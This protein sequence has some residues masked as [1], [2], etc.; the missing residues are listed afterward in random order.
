MEKTKRAK[1]LEAA[2]AVLMLTLVYIYAGKMP[3]LKASTDKA[4]TKTKEEENVKTVVIDPGHGGID[5]GAVSVR[6]A[7]EKDINLSIGLMLRDKLKE[8]G[9]A[10]VMTRETD[11]GLYGDAASN[12]K[13]ADMKARC[14]LINETEP[15]IMV[16]IHQNNYQ[17]EGVKGAQTFYYTNSSEGERAAAI[18]QKHLRERLDRDNER[19]AKANNNYYILIN[20]KCPAVIA[21]CGFLSNYTEA[22]LLQSEDYQEKVAEALCEGVCEYLGEKTN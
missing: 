19:Q 2:M 8:R 9:I 6:G 15:D 18:L 14:Q 17:S 22:E 12:K 4:E 11:T 21:E 16:S 7:S 20:V 13:V 5:G 10:V 3:A 1:W